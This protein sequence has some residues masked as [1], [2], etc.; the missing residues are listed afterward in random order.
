[1]LSVKADR[2]AHTTPARTIQALVL[3]KAQTRDRFPPKCKGA[4]KQRTAGVRAVA[5]SGAIIERKE[6]A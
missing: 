6:E 4:K 2:F 5:G 3:R 1:M